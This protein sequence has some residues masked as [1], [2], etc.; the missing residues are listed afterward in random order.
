VVGEFY[1]RVQAGERVH[2]EDYIA[3]PA[4]L[5]R[6]ASKNEETWS[7]SSYL[8]RADLERGFG[9]K[10]G[11]PPPTGVGANQPYPAGLGKVA[12]LAVAALLAVAIGK[13]EGAPPVDRLH[14]RFAVPMLVAR[15][16]VDPA[17]GV[18]PSDSAAADPGGDPPGSVMFSDKFHLDGGRN[19]AFELTANVSNNWVYAAL[20]LVNDDTGTVITF[21]KTIEYYSGVDDGESWNEGSTRAAEVL[22]PVEPGTYTLRV[23]AQHGGAGS[24]DLGVTV[25]QGVFR[26]LWFWIALGVLGVPLAIIALHAAGFRK[27]RWENSNT[28]AHASTGDDD[29]D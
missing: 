4:M 13:C 15:P 10:L 9:K 8:T 3:P 2:G 11:L 21:D 14:A 23:E 29:D 19:V 1:W 25:Q 7:L 20:D 6:E 22:A 12:A 28:V 17:L 24:V 5:S 16:T 27:R 18:V 26:W